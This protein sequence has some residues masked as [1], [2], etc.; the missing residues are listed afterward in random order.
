M[1]EVC[2]RLGE[3]RG[4]PIHL[5]PLVMDVPGPFGLWINVSVAD[6]I[7]Y[8]KSGTTPLHQE[9][10]IAHELGHLIADHPSDVG[11]DSIWQELMPDIPLDVIHR[12][13]R[14]RT[15][16]DNDYEQEAE[17]LATVLL[18]ATAKAQ[19]VT[20]PGYSAR[21]RRAQTTLGDPIDLL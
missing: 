19:F 12:A 15:S 3:R 16:Y 2:K 5:L 11:D 7:V 10:I 18:E 8:Q 20:L 17:T 4:K 1:A 9:H 13:L 14:G 6:F 21:A